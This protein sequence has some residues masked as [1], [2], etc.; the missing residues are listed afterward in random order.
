M[1]THLDVSVTLRGDVPLVAI[2]GELDIATAPRLDEA[3]CEAR[4]N[5]P[6]SVIVSLVECS[7]CDSSGLTVLLR[8]AKETPIFVLVAP[9]GSNV[10]RFLRIA[11]AEEHLAVVDTLLDALRYTHAEAT[12]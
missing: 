8:H 3:L 10:R 7:Y 9:K 11:G 4:S 6:F 1:A 5:E 2:G 12:A